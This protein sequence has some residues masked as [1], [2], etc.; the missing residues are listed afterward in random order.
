MRI[1]NIIV[2]LIIIFNKPSYSL[3][4][5]IV[6]KVNNNIITTVDILNEYNYLIALNKNLE[7]LEKEKIYTLA[8][9]SIIRENI[10]KSEIEKYINIDDLNDEYNENIFKNF[11]L[12]LGMDNKKDF[13][14]YLSEYN[15]SFN[16]VKRKILIEI[17][18]NNYIYEKFINQIMVNEELMKKKL[19]NKMKEKKPSKYYSL[20]E[21]LFQ[22]N[23]EENLNKK[24]KEITENIDKLGFETT[25]S[26][27][28]SSNTSKN[29]GKLGWVDEN[30]ISKN[31][32]KHLI[33]LDKGNYTNPIVIPGGFLVI[34]LIDVK[35]E[36]NNKNF[37]FEEELKKAVQLEKNKQL[38]KYSKIYFNKIKKN[39]F[40]S[41]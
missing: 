30:T 38:D 24:F 29:G 27:Y 2:L 26:I 25:A 11:Y 13:E 41:E 7:N 35:I 16:Q 8:R 37:N 1:I 4:N 19:N 12:N 5:S 36:K 3:E 22:V 20:S 21:I 28:S 18:W 31:I 14:N 15:L 23:D 32:K 40:I 17:A 39:S 33:T 9:N 6:L 10:K 34:K